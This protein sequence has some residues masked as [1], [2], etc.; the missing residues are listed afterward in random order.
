[1]SHQA[2]G[3]GSFKSNIGFI[4]AAAGSAIGLGNI[5]GFPY[6]AASNGGG[7]FV[8]LYLI[9]VGIIGIPV[10]LAELSIG[11]ATEKSPVGAFKKLAPGTLWPALGGLGVIT[12]FAILAFYSTIAGWTVGYLYKAVAGHFTRGLSMVESEAVFTTFRQNA[13]LAVL[14]TAVFFLISI[15]VVRGGIRGG[16]ERASKILMPLFFILLTLLV[17]RS[18]TLPGSYAGVDFLFNF[19]LSKITATVVL[20]ALAQALFSMSLG[21]GAMITYGSY[22][23]RKENLPRAGI[24][25][26]F[27]DTLLALMAGLMIFPALFSAG[28][29]PAGEEGLVFVVLP[30][31]F[32]SLPLGNVFAIAFYALLTIA[33][34]TSAISLLEVIVSYFVDERGWSREKSTWLL[35]TACFL[36]AVPCTAIDGFM[37]ILVQVFWVY[38]LSVGA[39]LICLF[40][41]WK[42]GT[43]AARAEMTAD[44]A[45]FPGLAV[46]AFLVKWVCPV[47]AGVILLQRVWDLLRPLLSG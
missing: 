28:G 35:G 17:I 27:F 32:D 19:D 11:R 1:M 36:L 4:L 8:L 47:L 3:R 5:W 30:T 37:G 12:G 46:W 16:I 23:S 15:L 13:P 14:A 22:L 39:L 26:A 6:M 21:M 31:I 20:G 44:G 41:G 18:V 38:S 34:L 9:C 2:P 29:Q 25:V 40:V 7:A 10:L 42:W 45:T 33:A 24:T 43:S